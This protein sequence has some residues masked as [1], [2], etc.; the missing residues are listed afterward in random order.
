M[1]VRFKQPEGASGAAAAP[2]KVEV[3]QGEYRRSFDDTSGAYDLSDT[4]WDI[5]SGTR[6]FNVSR[7]APGA[8]DPPP[9]PI[10][11][12]PVSEEELQTDGEIELIQPD[13]APASPA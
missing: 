6:L 3:V 1:K 2:G 11:N 13:A 4:E 7:V 12:P 8:Y 10:G 9:G 5:L